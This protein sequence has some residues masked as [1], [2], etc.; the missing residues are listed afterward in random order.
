[1]T[2]P[3]QQHENPKFS[4]Q[5]CCQDTPTPNGEKKEKRKMPKDYMNTTGRYMVSRQAS[6]ALQVCARTDTENRLTLRQQA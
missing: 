3:I 4:K 1:M 2:P 6:T 5:K